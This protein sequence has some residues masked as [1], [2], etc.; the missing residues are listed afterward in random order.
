MAI[1][2]SENGR[3]GMFPIIFRRRNF[4]QK[5]IVENIVWLEISWDR[6]ECRKISVEKWLEVFRPIY[7][8][9][10]VVENKISTNSDHMSFRQYLRPTIS[11]IFSTNLNI[12]KNL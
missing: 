12:F 10:Q 3:K 8:Q 1:Y 5:S 2:R 7:D 4:H 6:N 9:T 11:D